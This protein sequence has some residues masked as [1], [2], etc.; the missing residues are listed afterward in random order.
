[1]RP[2]APAVSRQ[3]REGHSGFN[4]TD[5]IAIVSALVSVA[6][7]AYT[8][9]DSNDPQFVL[10]L[11]LVYLVLTSVGLSVVSHWELMPVHTATA[12]M[13]SWIGAVVLMLLGIVPVPPA[14][15]LV[16]G[17][18]SVSMNLLT[19]WIG[20]A[21]GAWSYESPSDILGMHWPDYLLVG[22]AVVISKVV[23]TLGGQ[24]TKAREM[25]SYRLVKLLG[26]GGMGEV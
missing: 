10:D 6:L 18:V 24:V 14:K 4:V 19:M 22:V 16:A 12:P 23:T 15:M 11:G 7:F 1:M 21:R 17:F 3:W 5:V 2:W 26:K 25:G 20:H 8:R 9:R 13:I